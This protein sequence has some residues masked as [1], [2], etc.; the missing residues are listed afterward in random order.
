MQHVRVHIHAT[1]NEEVLIGSCYHSGDSTL[2]QQLRDRQRH[3]EERFLAL[4][5]ANDLLDDDGIIEG[6][7][8]S[9]TGGRVT[10]R[11]PHAGLCTVQ[12]ATSWNILQW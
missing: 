9:L 11:A 3:A 2:K 4:R 7:F 5:H 12:V 8:N 10:G 6:I 1:N